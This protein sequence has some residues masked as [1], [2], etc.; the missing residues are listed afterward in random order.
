MSHDI[1]TAAAKGRDWVDYWTLAFIGASAFVLALYTYYTR[2]L[3]KATDAAL[4][5]AQES[6]EKALTETRKSNKA[7]KK[8]NKIAKRTLELGK[9]AWL[10]AELNPV[11]SEPLGNWAP[12]FQHYQIKVTN[13]GGSPATNVEVWCSF[14][15]WDAMQPTDEV[16]DDITPKNNH[17]LGKGSVIGA[18]MW[19]H[20]ILSG[21]YGGD[22]K[23]LE[24]Y[25]CKITYLDFFNQPRETVACWQHRQSAIPVEWWT[26]ASSKHNTLK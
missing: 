6:S 18:G 11:F 22:P 7:T 20:W 8:S 25:Y 5:H 10:V 17:L 4:K 19:H 24:T 1:F 21:E 16:P 14:D 13:V 15:R 12:W 23:T 9:R 3:M 2:R 26:T